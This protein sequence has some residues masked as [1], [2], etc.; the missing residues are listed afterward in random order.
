MSVNS[1][2]IKK[3]KLGDPGL[4]LKVISG[5]RRQFNEVSLTLWLSLWKCHSSRMTLR[6]KKTETHCCLYQ[7][8]FQHY[9]YINCYKCVDFVGL[10]LKKR[11]IIS[12]FW[13]VSSHYC[14]S[15]E[16]NPHCN[17]I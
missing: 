7:I 12:M 15:E 8:I 3:W 1:E 4:V 2:T 11:I 17:K 14:C 10:Q 16:Y 13:H 5:K 6:L 9:H